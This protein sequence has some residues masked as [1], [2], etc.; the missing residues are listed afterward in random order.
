MTS[1]TGGSHAQITPV[2]DPCGL[3]IGGE[4]DRNTRPWLAHA[5]AWAVAAC[6]GD[7]HLDLG[8]LTFIDAAAL[9]LIAHVATELPAPRRLILDPVPP[10]ARRLLK[11]LGWQVGGDMRLYT[12]VNGDSHPGPHDT[13][14]AT[15]DEPGS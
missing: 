5:L 1:L 6:K 13:P 8:A 3:R 15:P 4:I 11:V 10:L 2:V 14:P 12:P 7:V 9:R